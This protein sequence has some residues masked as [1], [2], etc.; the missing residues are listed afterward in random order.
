MTLKIGAMFVAAAALLSACGDEGCTNETAQKKMMDLN[1]K[2]QAMA[3]TAPEKMVAA[4]PKMQE[5]G[6]KLQAGSDIDAVC[7]AIDEMMVELD[8]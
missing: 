7:K 5:I 3:A 2:V 1:T 4:A 6:T 8:K